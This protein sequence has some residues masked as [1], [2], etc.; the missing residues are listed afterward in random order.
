MPL[1]RLHNMA[2]IRLNAGSTPPDRGRYF[3]IM[4]M[5]LISDDGDFYGSQT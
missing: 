5:I 4:S 3:R 1:A 2:G